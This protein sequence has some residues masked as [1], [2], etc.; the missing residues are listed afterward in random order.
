MGI[1][2][3]NWENYDKQIVHMVNEK[4]T[5]EEISAA[6]I[7]SPGVV[8]KRIIDLGLR[9]KRK[10]TKEDYK[11]KLHDVHSKKIKRRCLNCNC[12]FISESPFL[13]LCCSCRKKATNRQ[14][15]FTCS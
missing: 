15:I 14:G 10:K 8:Q 1:S 12:R 9:G 6:L 7:L 13:R 11:K 4:W 3:K 5:N 2:L